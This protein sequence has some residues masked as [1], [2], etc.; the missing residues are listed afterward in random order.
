MSSKLSYR[1]RLAQIRIYL[2]KM[3]RM[4]VYQNDWKVMPMAALIAGLVTVAV[5]ANLFRTQEGTMQGCFALACVCVWNGFFNSIQVICR[6]RPIVKREH[7]SGMHISSYIAAHMIYQMLL[8]IGQTAIIIGVC[9]V[10]DVRFPSEG[11]VTPWFLCD[12]ALTLFLTTYAA[13]MLSLLVSALVHSTTTAMTVMPFLLI[14]QLLFSGG[15]VQ[16]GEQL[17]KLTD[18]TITKWGLKG[19]CALGDYNGRPMVG[20]WNMIWRFRGLEFVI[21]SDTGNDVVYPV[22]LI[23][24]RIQNEG[25]LDAFLQK[26]GEYVQNPEYAHTAENLLNCWWHLFVMTAAAA[27]IAMLLLEFVDRDRR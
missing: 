8:C 15:L 13:D 25:K 11:L 4:F 2:G 9:Y 21:P 18:F 26:A 16:L 20:L 27:L 22:A 14:F 19:M 5:G 23:T 1:G 12:F 10:S 17:A 6:E 7:R 24:D 3:L